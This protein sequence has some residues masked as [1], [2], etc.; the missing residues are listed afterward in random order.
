MYKLMHMKAGSIALVT[1]QSMIIVHIYSKR[2]HFTKFSV[3]F[4]L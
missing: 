1:K 4:Q 2:L 3:L